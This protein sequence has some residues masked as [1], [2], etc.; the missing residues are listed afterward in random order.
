MVTIPLEKELNNVSGLKE[1]TSHSSRST[2]SIELDFDMDKN[3]DEAIRDVQ[4]ALNRAEDLCP[5]GWTTSLSTTNRKTV[6]NT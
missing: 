3:I 6:P 4:A 5:K 2:T 1:M